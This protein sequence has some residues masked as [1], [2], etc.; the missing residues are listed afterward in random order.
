MFILK[1]SDLRPASKIRVNF[2]HHHPHKNEVHRSSHS[3]QVNFGP[4]TV[5]YDPPHKKQVT[6]DP[7]A[8]TKSNSIPHKEMKLISTPLLKSK[9]SSI[10]TL[11]SSQFGC[12]HTKTKLI[13]IHTLTPSVFEPHSITKSIRI[14]AVKSSQFPS[15]L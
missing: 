9:V 14:S 10:P 5:N 7:N 12:L 11:K 1:P 15:P 13:S 2:D 3:K 8:K 4:L 6:F